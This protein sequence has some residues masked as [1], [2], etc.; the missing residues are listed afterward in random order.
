MTDR[1]IMMAITHAALASAAVPLI[2]SASNPMVLGLAILGS[3][4]PDIDTTSS[5]TGQVFYPISNRL[6]ERYPHRTAT[7]SFLAV[8][9]VSVVWG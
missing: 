6:E 5:L 4:L 9:I 1:R 8:A 3:Q 2:L 7:H